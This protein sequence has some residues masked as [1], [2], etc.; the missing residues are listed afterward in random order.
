MAEA[1]RGTGVRLTGR[2]QHLVC[3]TPSTGC[4]EHRTAGWARVS[5]PSEV[6]EP[7]VDER[8]VASCRL[9][10]SLTNEGAT[11]LLSSVQ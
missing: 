10:T 3:A 1:S 4:G 9:P 8:S 7:P 2:A 5:L 11:Q 6:N